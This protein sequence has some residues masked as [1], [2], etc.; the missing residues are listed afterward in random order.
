MRRFF[1]SMIVFLL[2]LDQSSG[3]ALPQLSERMKQ[4]RS[5][6]GALEQSLIEGLKEQRQ[7]KA[8]LAKL[9][10]LI[11]L[12]EEERTLGQ[13]RIQELEQAVGDLEERRGL[14]RE[15]VLVQSRAI[16]VE[17]K[18][19]NRSMNEVPRTVRLPEREKIE[20]PRRK[21]L[22]R[23]V[24]RRLKE[25]EVFKVDLEDADRLEAKIREERAQLEYV[26]QELQE[27][28]GIMELSRD[29][30]VDLLKK[31]QADRVQQLEA[32]RK[33][34]GAEM[35]VE[36][37]LGE[38]NAR[39]ELEHAQEVEKVASHAMKE[40]QMSQLQGRLPL[41]VVGK[42][43]SSFGRQLDQQSGLYVF[44]K[45]I[46]IEASPRQAVKSVSPGKVVYSGE[47]TGYGRVTIIDHGR[48]VY[49]LCARLSEL[50]KKT[51]DY[52]ALGDVIGES[53]ASGK[54]VYFEIR[55][56]NVAVNPL[57]WVTN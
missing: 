1:F 16:R 18:D 39:K 28:K 45:G 35:Q 25:I 33:L 56:R 30:Q 41:P 37:L 9:R 22:S 55:S 13:R 51:G 20:A 5:Q 36:R 40:G 49:S 4:V 15:K 10:R 27:Q 57:Q 29:L 42:V 43:V 26:V 50:Q 14:L 34:R 54:P 6:I 11:E 48:Q 44:K 53:D 8:N 19:L 23:M 24:D 32:Y 52:V 31:R 21:V 3:A 46:E 38:F 7:A 17:L 2:L 47:L 12:Q